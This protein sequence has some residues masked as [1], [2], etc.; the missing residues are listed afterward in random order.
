MRLLRGSL[1]ATLLVGVLIAACASPEQDSQSENVSRAKFHRHW[2]F[3]ISRGTLI[4]DGSGGMGAVVL[5]A[6]D[7]TLYAVNGIARGEGYTHAGSR[8]VDFEHRI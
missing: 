7:G 3:T 8:P 2:P 1:G 4:C 5:K 6:P